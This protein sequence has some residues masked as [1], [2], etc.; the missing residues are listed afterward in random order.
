MQLCIFEI[1]DL[2]FDWNSP[3]PSAPGASALQCLL[4]Q[5]L[6]NKRPKLWLQREVS[7][8]FYYIRK[9]TTLI[10]SREMDMENMYLGD[11]DTEHGC[12]KLIDVTPWG[13]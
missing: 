13:I 1:F 5:Q 12:E 4:H 8:T 9:L 7:K 6:H 11:E 3:S 2:G 10:F